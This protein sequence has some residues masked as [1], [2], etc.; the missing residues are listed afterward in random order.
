MILLD[1]L[2]LEL[3]GCRKEMEEL[4]ALLSEAQKNLRQLKKYAISRLQDLI[5]RYGVVVFNHAGAITNEGDWKM[6]FETFIG[7]DYTP[8]VWGHEENGGNGGNGG[9]TDV[10]ED[11]I[12]PTLSAPSI[13]VTSDRRG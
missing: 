4:N 7:D 12:E 8:T 1:E 3:V 6:L 11:R 2:R 5:D 13:A 10:P 9:G